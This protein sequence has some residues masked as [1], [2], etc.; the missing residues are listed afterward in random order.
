LI[1]VSIVVAMSRNFGIGRENQLPWHLPED[2][3]NFK[4]IT[5]G[6]PIIMGRKTF[7]SIGR[8]LPGRTNIVVTR[9]RG[10]SSNTVLVAR[11]FEEAL[12]LA[13]NACHQNDRKELMVIGGE[14]IY[15]AAL[16]VVSRI[17]LTEVKGDIAAD[18]FF[19]TFDRSQWVEQ[20]RRRGKIQA[21]FSYDFVIL[22]KRC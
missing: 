2:L 16:P 15:R 17:Y 8:P 11:G 9:N 6:K 13:K 4:A 12:L 21:D 1:T 14:M 3:K 20:N 5:M 10:W 7:D 22:D 18:T 19:P